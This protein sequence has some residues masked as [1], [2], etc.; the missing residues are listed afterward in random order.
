MTVGTVTVTGVATGSADL[1]L[2]A[3]SISNESGGQYRIGALRGATVTVEEVAPIVGDSDARATDPDSD[4]VYE[5]VNGD[6][7]VTV[8]DATLLLEAIR[9]GDSA[10]GPPFDVNRDG[11]V[12]AIDARALFA[13]A[14]E[15][16]A[17]PAEGGPRIGLTLQPP[18]EDGLEIEPRIDNA[19]V[20]PN[21][22][23]TYQLT[24]VIPSA[25]TDGVGAYELVVAVDDPATARITGASDAINGSAEVDLAEDGSSVRIA[26]F[27]GDAGTGDLRVVLASVTVTGVSP[28]NATLTVEPTSVSDET[29]AN[30][31]TVDTRGTTLTVREP[32][33]T[34]GASSNPA[35]DPDRDGLYEDVNGDGEAT[36]GDATVLF[37]AVFSRDPAVLDNVELFDFTD[38]DEVT[39]GDATV[40]FEEVF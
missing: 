10:L 25:E 23:I 40:L 7:A 2:R 15:A 24:G 31:Y 3:R 14:L 8:G 13:A 16:D 28:G 18:G 36:P 39:P 30:R 22:S 5:D 38:D 34:V 1:S 27:G 11:I 26:A 37:N 21:G 12:N 19:S 33:P 6:R 4:G 29:G 35:T 32:V 20:E 17:P 9:A